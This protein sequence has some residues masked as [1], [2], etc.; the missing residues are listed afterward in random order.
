MGC[1]EQ[2]NRCILFFFCFFLSTVEFSSK[3]VKTGERK[4]FLF[5]STSYPFC[6][7]LFVLELPSYC[8]FVLLCMHRTVW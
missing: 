4:V 1:V 7:Q 3:S 6:D 8:I 5:T 2:K